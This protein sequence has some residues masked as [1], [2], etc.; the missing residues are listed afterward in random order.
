MNEVLQFWFKENSSEQW[1]NKDDAFDQLLRD[2]F[3]DTL[4]RASR[5]ELYDWR[6]TP[7]GRVAEIVVLDQFSR[8][9]RRGTPGSFANDAAALVLAQEIVGSGLLEALN[10]EERV[11]ALMPYMHSESKVIHEQADRLFKQWT[12]EEN[13]GF[14]LRHK[15]I[16]DRFD[17]YP[18][19]NAI[20][21]RTSTAEELE[22]L[23]QP[24][25]SF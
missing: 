5:G 22:F 9:I 25:S 3:G 19:R 11:F 1:F 14:E 13:H 8:N 16:I 24:D 4:E 6:A 23:T 15:V 21:G 20:L 12:P 2:R 17:R 18:H 10:A 7:Q